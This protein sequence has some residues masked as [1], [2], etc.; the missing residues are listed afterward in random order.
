MILLSRH[1]KYRYF[2]FLSYPLEFGRVLGD[3]LG[4]LPQ[5]LDGGLLSLTA[6]CVGALDITRLSSRHG[7][8]AGSANFVLLLPFGGFDDHLFPFSLGGGV[9]FLAR[10]DASPRGSALTFMDFTVPFEAIFFCYRL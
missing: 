10:G 6:P 7:G 8:V 5:L 4:Y 1:V 2:V 3:P 9:C